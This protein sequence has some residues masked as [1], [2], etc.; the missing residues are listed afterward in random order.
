MFYFGRLK[1]IDAKS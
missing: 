1:G